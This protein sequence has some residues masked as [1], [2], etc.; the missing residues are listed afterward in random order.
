MSSLRA[1]MFAGLCCMVGV[2]GCQT[3]GANGAP[4]LPGTPGYSSPT[5]ASRGTIRS[6]STAVRTSRSPR[7][8]GGASLARPGVSGGDVARHV[9]GEES[10]L[11]ITLPTRRILAILGQVTVFRWIQHIE[12]VNPTGERRRVVDHPGVASTRSSPRGRADRSSGGRRASSG[13]HRRGH[14]RDEGGT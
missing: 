13:D 4:S 14:R 3:G 11:S 12:E 8:G 2:P 6:T 9:A 1:V 10:T 5:G 7:R